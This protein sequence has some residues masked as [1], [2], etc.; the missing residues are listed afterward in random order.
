MPDT[1]GVTVAVPCVAGALVHVLPLCPPPAVQLA[2]FC[3]FHVSV[4]GFP[5]LTVVGAADSVTVG[6]VIA[7]VTAALALTPCAVQLRP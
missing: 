1:V 6:T 5:R 4:T 3:E 7:T 2:A